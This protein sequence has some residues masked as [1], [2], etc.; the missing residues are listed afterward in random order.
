MQEN[1]DDKAIF[2]SPKQ[3]VF[4]RKAV[5]GEYIVVIEAF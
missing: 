2:L 3:I 1:Y 4:G 5:D